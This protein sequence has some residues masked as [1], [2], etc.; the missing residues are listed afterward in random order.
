MEKEEKKNV[1]S[2]LATTG[3]T[4]ADISNKDTKDSDEQ[5]SEV[6]VKKEIESTA[7]VAIFGSVLEN[8]VYGLAIGS[9][10][11]RNI[12]FGLSGEF[13]KL[14]WML[15]LTL[16]SYQSKKQTDILFKSVLPLLQ[17]LFLTKS[18]TSFNL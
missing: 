18:V 11:H 9:S 2:S 7:Y 15:N 17:K 14:T 5:E 6:E 16:A 13:L 10:W 12:G 1:E 3:V 8:I 4:A